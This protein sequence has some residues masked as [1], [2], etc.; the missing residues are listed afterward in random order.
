MKKVGYW[1]SEKKRKKLNFDD[2]KEQCRLTNL[3]LVQIDLSKSLEEQGPFDVIIH[4]L[5]DVIA[6]ADEGDIKCQNMMKNLQDYIHY[7]PGVVVIDPLQSVRKLLKRHI[8]YKLIQ[9]CSVAF[10]GLDPEVG[11]PNFVKIE[12]TDRN[13]IV[14]LMNLAEV[15]FPIVC[16][17]LQGHGSSLSH[18]M[19][20]IFNE[21][22]LK[23][24]KPPCVAQTFVN[25]NAKLHKL[26]IIGDYHYIVE[27]PSVKNFSAGD[28][29]T[30]FFDSHDVSKANSSSFL[31]ELDESDLEDLEEVPPCTNRFSELVH[32]VRS[33]LGMDLF[34][35]DVVIENDTRKHAVIDINAFPGYDGVPMFFDVLL[36]HIHSLL[37][38]VNKSQEIM[39]EVSKTIDFVK[40]GE[41]S[42]DE[43]KGK[44]E[45]G[46]SCHTDYDS[47]EK[48]GLDEIADPECKK[49]RQEESILH[50]EQRIG[51]VDVQCAMLTTPTGVPNTDAIEINNSTTVENGG[52]GIV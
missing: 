42:K 9:D 48:H 37:G 44:A 21:E 24:V 51:K 26:F 1:L 7:N 12:T 52:N 40:S 15:E 29:T 47:T 25:H 14:R 39:K 5:T 30:I 8:S 13:E 49:S 38:D 20:I 32:S 28:K 35:I 36:A 10:Q 23:D 18:M 50:G 33:R 17:A 34:G 46:L 4:K 31:N 2:F 3:D 11:T 41:T 19:A 43:L 6:K 22:G 45:N 16:K 27:R